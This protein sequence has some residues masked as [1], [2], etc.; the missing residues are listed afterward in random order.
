VLGPPGAGAVV[1]VVAG[2]GDAGVGEAGATVGGGVGV[3][4]GSAFEVA[5][6]A[7]VTALAPVTAAIASVAHRPLRR[8]EVGST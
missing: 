7:M 4:S 5:G 6:N 1:G 2:A 3:G 8:V